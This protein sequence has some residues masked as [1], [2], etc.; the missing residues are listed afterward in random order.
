MLTSSAAPGRAPR[1]VLPAGGQALPGR[2]TG[3]FTVTARREEPPRPGVP[4]QPGHG[5]PHRIQPG[6]PGRAVS[7][8]S[9]GRWSSC[10]WPVSRSCIQCAVLGTEVLMEFIGEAGRRGLPAGRAATRPVP[11]WP[12]VGELVEAAGRWPGTAW[13]TA[14]CRPTTSWSGAGGDDRPAQSSTSSPT[15]RRPAT[16]SA[17]PTTSRAGSPRAD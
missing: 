5:G 8:A 1:A 15:R 13:P 10:S 17:T 7:R 14:T 11:C 16:W 4:T 3:C 6:G 12:R 9:S 2:R